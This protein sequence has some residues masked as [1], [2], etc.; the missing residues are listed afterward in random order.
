MGKFSFPFPWNFDERVGI[1][2]LHHTYDSLIHMEK[3]INVV[4]DVSAAEAKII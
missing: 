4:R 2:V 1:K 3:V